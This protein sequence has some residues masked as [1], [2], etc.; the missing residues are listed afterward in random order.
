MSESIGKGVYNWSGLMMG[1]GPS[2]QGEIGNAICNTEVMALTMAF[3]QSA[4]V[5]VSSSCCWTPLTNSPAVAQDEPSIMTVA[6]TTAPTEVAVVAITTTDRKHHEECG[7]LE[8]Y[9]KMT[10]AQKII[11]GLLCA[12]V[13]LEGLY[14]FA[15]VVKYVAEWFILLLAV[16]RR[17]K[18]LRSQPRLDYRS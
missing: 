9:E 5:S 2:M 12:V 13:A 16:T 3:L 7:I 17:M 14:L 1:D 18:Q 10:L 8:L 6:P 4:E 11:L 15:L